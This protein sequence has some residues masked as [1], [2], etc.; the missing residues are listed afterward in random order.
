MAEIVSRRLTPEEQVEQLA[1]AYHEK[2]ERGDEPDRQ[3]VLDAHPDIAEILERRLALVE[4]IYGVADE[5]GPVG[6]K[7]VV[8]EQAKTPT[9]DADALES[10]GA[11][12]TP[13]RIGPYR[14]VA[15]LGMGGMGVV[16]L[17][18]QTDPIRRRVAIKVIRPGMDTKEAIARFVLER[19]ALAMMCHPHIVQIYDAA[20]MENG[21]PYFTMEYINGTAITEYADARRLQIQDRLEL[22]CQFCEG[23]Q[24]AHSKG[25][26]HRSLKPSDVLV[27]TLSGRQYVKIID[28]GVAQM[29]DT[30]FS[31]QEPTTERGQMVGTPEYMSP[32]MLEISTREIDPRADIYHMG[33]ILYQLL[34]GSLPYD[35]EGMRA[36]GLEEIRL[37][38]GEEEPP[39]PSVRVNTMGDAAT[40]VA[41]FRG[42]NPSALSRSIRGELDWITMKAMARNRRRRYASAAELA[43][44]IQRFLSGDAVLAAPPSAAYRFRMRLMKSRLALV[45][46]GAVLVG[47]TFGLGVLTAQ[48]VGDTSAPAGAQAPAL[49]ALSGAWLA[50]AGWLGFRLS[51]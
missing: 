21:R 20:E 50:C 3:A 17:A 35:L 14:I 51:R 1:E 24:H 26:I 8:R 27:T 38:A 30:E 25:I 44:D 19:Q 7:G 12:D 39:W 49:I 16:Y 36:A 45:A 2:L 23:V 40:D 33:I 11:D 48:Y 42:T 37:R 32:E 10:G 41:M 15:P 18:E 6:E 29:A 4:L 34:A 31:E 43:V 13:G 47:V 22:F 5:R 46:A 9:N 28:F